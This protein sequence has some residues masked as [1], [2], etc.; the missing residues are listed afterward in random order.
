MKIP[1]CDLQILCQVL[2]SRVSK[3]VLIVKEICFLICEVHH[4]YIDYF[5]EFASCQCVARYC[6]SCSREQPQ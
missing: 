1:L 3:I 2:C 5:I 6:F 4:S